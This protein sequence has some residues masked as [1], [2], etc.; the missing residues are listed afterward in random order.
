MFTGNAGFVHWYA[1]ASRIPVTVEE[2]LITA[3]RRHDQTSDHGS[4]S[5]IRLEPSS[6][7]KCPAV[8]A[9]CFESVEPADIGEAHA[10]EVDKLRCRDDGNK[11]S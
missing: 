8:D 5:R 4:V 6:V 11:P 2:H 7:R 1:Y 10:C 9:L 3:D